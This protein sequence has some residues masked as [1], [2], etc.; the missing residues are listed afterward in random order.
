MSVTGA[1]HM[2]DGDIVLFNRQPSLHKVS[3]MAHK[4][5]VLEWRTFRFN[6]CVCAPYNADFDG[7][8]MNMHLPQ[9]EESRS[10]ASLLMGVVN[11]LTTPRNG[12]P[13]VA[14]S[15]DFL[16]ASYML[17]QRDQF[18]TRDQFCQIVSY[19]G[20][21]DEEINFPTPAIVKPIE[22]WTGKQIFGQVI[23]PN[24]ACKVLCNFEAKDKNYTTNHHFCRNDG[25]VCFRNSELISGNIAKKTIG[26]GSKTGLLYVLLRDWGAAEAARI[27]DR[28]SRL[29]GRWMGGH[30]GFSIGI[31]DVTP[32]EVLRKMKHDILLEG[33]KRVD[34]SIALYEK[35][36]LD[37]RPGCDLL[38]SLE[39]ILNGILG[40]LR[41]SAGQEAMKA[42]PWSNA[43]RIMADCGSKGSPLNI[44]QMAACVGQQQV[45]GMRIADGFLNRTL[46]QFEVNSLS[47]AS[48]GFVANSFFTGLS[49]T[50]F[51][52]HAM[53]GREG[54]VSPRFASVAAIV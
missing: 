2:E 9:T 29:C 7:D 27:M 26:D 50:E 32:S 40:R 14:A 17:T 53:G 22:L 49:A 30:K 37:L 34:Q 15:Q 16:S 43:P 48:K 28:W 6:T 52:F 24:K 5:K 54:D 4:V 42:L 45:E 10:E 21:A 8:E 41:E 35:G 12:E 36:A 51:F 3:I 38:Q 25:W 1:R 19:L 11:N 20:D 18:F 44:S 31:S 39:E 23:R 46:P 47:P 33:F 13:L